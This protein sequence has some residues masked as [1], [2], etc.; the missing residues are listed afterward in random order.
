MV[1]SYPGPNVNI[2]DHDHNTTSMKNNRTDTGGLDAEN[3][4]N[5]ALPWVNLS[6]GVT[7]TL[8]LLCFISSMIVT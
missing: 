5:G 3:A 6:A 1:L 7:F 2:N 4:I 8:S